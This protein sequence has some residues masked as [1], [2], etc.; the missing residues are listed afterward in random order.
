MDPDVPEG[1]K[2]KRGNTSAVV[3]QRGQDGKWKNI[4]V[5]CG[6]TFLEQARKFFPIWGVQTIDAVLLT[7]GRKSARI[8]SDE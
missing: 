2:N 8:A 6:K 5:D 1:Y 3:R 4:L 7:H